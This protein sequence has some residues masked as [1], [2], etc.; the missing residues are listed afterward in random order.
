MITTMKI[1]RRVKTQW[2]FDEVNY[3]QRVSLG[4]ALLVENPSLRTK[5]FELVK[6][7]M[8]CLLEKN[9]WITIAIYCNKI[10]LAI[11]SWLWDNIFDQFDTI[12]AKRNYYL[13]F[14]KPGKCDQKMMLR[15]VFVKTQQWCFDEGLHPP[16]YLQKENVDNVDNKTK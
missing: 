7:E 9:F 16:E 14:F 5:R 1:N 15:N 4:R 2:T 10:F 13:F 6:S 11:D 3:H 8:P 12:K